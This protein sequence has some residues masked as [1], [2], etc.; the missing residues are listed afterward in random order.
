MSDLQRCDQKRT[1]YGIGPKMIP[2]IFCLL[3]AD[4]VGDNGPSSATTAARSLIERYYSC[5]RAAA[6][7]VPRGNGNQ[8]AEM[9]FLSCQTEEAAMAALL[10][11]A[12]ISPS[13]AQMMILRHRLALKQ[14]I[15][16][17]NN[18]TAR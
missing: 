12:G 2:M 3:L 5:V 1:R 14:E 11:N 17:V 10:A 18:P 4:C 8:I 15:V 6:K 16:Q 9:A 13:E 7:A